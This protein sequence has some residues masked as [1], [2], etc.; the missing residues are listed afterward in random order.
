MYSCANYR[1]PDN[2]VNSPTD[3]FFGDTWSVNTFGKRLKQARALAKL[4]QASLGSEV[5]LSQS[6]IS[7]LESGAQ[8]ETTLNV[9]LAIA[10]AVDPVWLVTGRG[11][12]KP[13][14]L[15]IIGIWHELDADRRSRLL[16]H[17]YDLLVGQRGAPIPTSKN[18]PYVGVVMP[19]APAPIRAKTKS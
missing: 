1:V 12:A 3:I 19:P 10:C 4:S 17:A 13:V 18:L 14:D 9:Q 8:L 15:A 16:A 11:D 5:G 7:D 2:R 6:V